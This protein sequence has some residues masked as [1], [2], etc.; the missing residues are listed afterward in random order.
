MNLSIKKT[1]LESLELLSELVESNAIVS[2][3]FDLLDEA[4]DAILENSD[5]LSEGHMTPKQLMA[6]RRNR[7][8][9]KSKLAMIARKKQKCMDRLKASGKIAGMACGS[10][11]T[12]HRINPKL[13][14]AAR[15]GAHG[16]RD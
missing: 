7:I 2:H 5:L 11:G 12:P 6:A 15:K 10:D 1:L 9:N 16:R 4:V 3:N 13:S 8:K 14:K